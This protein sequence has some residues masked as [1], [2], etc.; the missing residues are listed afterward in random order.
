MRS[1]QIQEIKAISLPEGFKAIGA[2]VSLMKPAE[3]VEGLAEYK[4]LERNEGRE[5][6]PFTYLTLQASYAYRVYLLL[7]KVAGAIYTLFKPAS[8]DE[9]GQEKTGAEWQKIDGVSRTTFKA[10]YPRII[11]AIKQGIVNGVVVAKAEVKTGA[12]GQYVR[13]TSLGGEIA[14]N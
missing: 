7:P 3:F 1:I 9:K 12:K 11:K 6:A 14:T 8:Y 2:K 5:K 4:R 13:I 10:D